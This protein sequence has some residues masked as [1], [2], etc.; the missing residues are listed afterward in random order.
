MKKDIENP[1]IRKNR[2]YHWGRR[3]AKITICCFSTD[4]R[5][6]VF[7]CVLSH[8]RVKSFSSIVCFFF[9]SF[10]F[11]SA[12]VPLREKP[13]YNPKRRRRSQ[14]PSSS[15]TI[16]RTGSRLSS[17]SPSVSHGHNNHHHHH[18]GGGVMV[19]SPSPSSR[20]YAL[21]SASGSVS[22]NAS[23]HGENG[24]QPSDDQCSTSGVV[25]DKSKF[26][27][28]SFVS[29]IDRLIDC[30]TVDRLID[31]SISSQMV[32]WLIDWFVLINY[33]ANRS[34]CTVYFVNW[35]VPCFF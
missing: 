15:S 2:T 31:W 27:D 32:D 28:I 10:S 4:E 7:P 12:V 30:S 3:K 14:S 1:V 35:M 33:F 9:F 18:H 11:S 6:V 8:N 5:V 23:S 34:S 24:S 25:T 21:F 17:R 13:S 20:S 19:A 26:R 29:P 22:S 16:S